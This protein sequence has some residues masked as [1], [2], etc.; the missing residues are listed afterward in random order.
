MTQPYGRTSGSG[1][2][3]E[4]S[5]RYPDAPRGGPTD[6]IWPRP[7]A[8][9]RHMCLFSIQG[10]VSKSVLATKAPPRPLPPAPRVIFGVEGNVCFEQ[11]CLLCTRRRHQAGDQDNGDQADSPPSGHRQRQE[12]RRHGEPGR[13]LAQGRQGPVRRGAAR[14]LSAPPLTARTPRDD[15]R[16][17]NGSRAG[18]NAQAVGPI[19]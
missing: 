2:I 4:R 1:P 3:A 7:V 13:Y 8:G 15:R 5:C 14:Y 16:P 18:C 6:W 17:A 9:C 12:Y 11:G 10:S 19:S